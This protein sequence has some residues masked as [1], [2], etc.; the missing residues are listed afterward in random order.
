MPELH[1]RMVLKYLTLKNQSRNK[2]FIQYCV[3]CVY[4]VSL[5]YSDLLQC[6]TERHGDLSVAI[7]MLD[8]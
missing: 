3:H 1:C 6:F 8:S 7:F 4:E 5:K 2:L